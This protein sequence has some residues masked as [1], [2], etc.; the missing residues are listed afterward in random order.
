MHAKWSPTISCCQQARPPGTHGCSWVHRA[1]GDDQG[2]KGPL[3]ARRGAPSPQECAL[4]G[5]C[6]DCAVVLVCGLWYVLCLFLA[7][8][9]WHLSVYICDL[10]A[11]FVC[12]T[13][14]ISTCDCHVFAC[15]CTSLWCVCM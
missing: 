9:Q 10:W 2:H 12:V 3:G 11:V 5:L 7:H 1:L 8:R 4:A 13:C 6:V 14:G 15:V